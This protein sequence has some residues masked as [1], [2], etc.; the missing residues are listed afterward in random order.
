[1]PTASAQRTGL[2]RASQATGDLNRSLDEPQVDESQES[3]SKRLPWSRLWIGR[4]FPRP[5]DNRLFVT[6]AATLAGRSGLRRSSARIAAERGP[7]PAAA[8]NRVIGVSATVTSPGPRRRRALAAAMHRIRVAAACRFARC[9]SAHRSGGSEA[10][11]AASHRPAC[12]HP[13]GVP[14]S[15]QPTGTHRVPG[16]G[17]PPTRSSSAIA[18]SCASKRRYARSSS[19]P[20]A[21]RSSPVATSACA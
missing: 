8:E 9:A 20:R 10:A 12:G 19:R 6:V 7:R 13:V 15:P 4:G 18:S 5:T 14:A 3:H 2:D 17:R 11:V 1:M 16:P 21:W